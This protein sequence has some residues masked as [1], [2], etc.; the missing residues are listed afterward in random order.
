MWVRREEVDLKLHPVHDRETSAN[1][2]YCS[3]ENC[4]HIPRAGCAHHEV[5]GYRDTGAIRGWEKMV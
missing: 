5:D 4:G 2:L 1:K 3:Q